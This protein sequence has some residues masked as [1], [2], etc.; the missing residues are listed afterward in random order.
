MQLNRANYDK[1]SY[2]SEI[3]PVLTIDYKWRMN[4]KFNLEPSIF[5]I[6]NIKKTS[7]TT[8]LKANYNNKYW[9]I[10]GYRSE[11]AIIFGAGV[12]LYKKFSLGYGLDI[13]MN[14]LSSNAHYSH[15]A[16]LNFQIQRRSTFETRTIGTPAF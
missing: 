6:T 11:D 12:I 7:L 14:K 13:R 8:T 16:Y 5:V 4:R 3:H 2:L 1:I 10:G 9:L 15:G